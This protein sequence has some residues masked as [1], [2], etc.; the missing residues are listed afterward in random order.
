MEAQALLFTRQ[1]CQNEI[2]KICNKSTA[3][4]GEYVENLNS[5]AD[6]TNPMGVYTE[7][8]SEL[9]KIVDEKDYL[10]ALRVINNKGLLPHTTLPNSFGWKKQ[11]Y[12]DYILRL[13]DTNETCAEEL[14]RVFKQYITL[15]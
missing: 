10:E 13:L 8:L 4:I 2:N 1:R 14:K 12:I 6:V 15:Q 9:Q 3:T 7:I 11:Y 5:I